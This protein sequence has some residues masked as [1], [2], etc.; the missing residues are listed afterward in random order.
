M[1]ISRIYIKNFRNF[2]EFDLS[3]PNGD[4]LT[5]IG[6]NNAGK[7]NLL[8]AIRLVL[9]TNLP[10][11]EKKLKEEDFSWNNKEKS[12]WIKGEEIVVTITFKNIIDKDEIEAFLQ[13]LSPEIEVDEENGLSANISFVFAPTIYNK[14]TEYNLEEDYLG[15]IVSGK[16]HPSGYEYSSKD[17]VVKYS[18]EILEKHSCDKI[19]NFYKYFY[20][21]EEDIE[22]IREDK[23]KSFE[24]RYIKQIYANKIK[25]HTNVLFLDATRDVRND[26]YQGYYSLVAQL[27]RLGIQKSNNFKITPEINDAFK[28][29]KEGSEIPETKKMLDDVEMGLQNDKVNFLSGKASM[30]IGIPKVTNE[31]I[32]KF[33]NFL[34]N[35][36]EELKNELEMNVIGLGYQNLAYISAI[37]SLFEMKKEI[38]ELDLDEK[39]KIIYNLLLI[40]EPEAHLDVQNQ[41]YLHT[42][43]EKRTEKLGKIEDDQK[44]FNF[45][46]V[47][48]T[49]HSTHLVSKSDLANIVILQKD[50]KRT[51]AVNIDKVLK[52]DILTYRHKRRILKQY[53]DATRSSLL[54][55]KRVVLVEGL[56][57]KYTLGSIINF[58]LKE[59]FIK[60][61]VDIDSEGIE[62]VEVGGKNFVPFSSIFN[63]DGLQNKCLSLK[64][65]DSQ[66]IEG[67][68]LDNYNNIYKERNNISNNNK[69]ILEK[70]NIFTFEIDMFFIPDPDDLNKNNIDYLKTI[71]FKFMSDGDYF[72][73]DETFANKI[74]KIDE[75][76]NKVKKFK[77]NKEEIK[78]FFDEILGA[79]VS[80]PSMSLYLSSILKAKLLGDKIEER[81]WSIMDNDFGIKNINELPNFVVPK[82]IEDGLKWLISEKN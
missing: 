45:T 63:M 71:L 60:N 7:T 54:F 59:K 33:F 79:E 21:S 37:F 38:V 66:L 82:Y 81:S 57:E 78:S 19:E 14:K 4:P 41:K 70:S 75:F 2:D 10:P 64:D 53:L 24:K 3:I 77:L 56:S 40:E 35:L 20:L 27:L 5:L 43:I 80:K 62:I 23:N 58:Y 67:V 26:F 52:E 28:K 34:I 16:Y 11:W 55:A 25:K 69:N 31:N 1:Y 18:E 44:H 50:T 72:K 8:Q 65:G 48:Q 6:G 30:T 49:S 74:K 12:P 42:Q 61:N 47:I 51:I 13:S 76:A 17:E 68:D 32:G 9:D 46:Q 39:Y 73:K 29:L 15:F 36:D 22:E